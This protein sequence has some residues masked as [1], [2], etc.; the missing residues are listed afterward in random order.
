MKKF[1]GNING[2]IY[3]D[4][5]EFEK[6]L[7]SMDDTGDV[8]V[9][10]KY[11]SVSDTNDNS[12][13]TYDTTPIRNYISE[14]QYVK[15]ITDKKDVDLDA[16]L[17]NKL[18]TSNNKSHIKD[19]VNKKITY[20]DKKISNNL[21]HINDLKSDRDKLEEKM[22]MINN[23]I[24]TLDDANN[25]Y[26]L[27]KE[28][29]TKINDLLIET[30][31]ASD[32]KNE[33]ECGCGCNDNECTCGCVRNECECGDDKDEAITVNDICKMSP[34]ELMKYFRNKKVYTLGDLVEYFIKNC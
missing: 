31:D 19:V 3:T 15:N 30:T 11:V 18:K 8:C 16:E 28:Y 4:K 25:N 17:I 26:Y 13:L 12:K 5:K 34:Y 33:H 21:L 20:F 10:Y 24:K 1:E 6:A 7:L 27:N 32:S 22:I 23:Q 9:S 2:K 14:D 29:Y